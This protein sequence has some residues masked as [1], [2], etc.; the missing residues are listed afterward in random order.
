MINI[1]GVS[2]SSIAPIAAKLIADNLQSL[3]IVPS[4]SRAKVLA[5]DLEYFTRKTKHRIIN[6][7]GWDNF[8]F[9]YDAKNHDEL[10]KRISA[11]KSLEEG[12]P[13]IIICPVSSAIKKIQPRDCFS[14]SSLTIKKGME[15]NPIEL[16]ENLVKMG[17]EHTEII[18]G[19]GQFSNRGGILDIFTPDLDN[20]VRIEFFGDEVDDIRIFDIDTQRSVDNL[21]EI[22]VYPAIE[23]VGNSV[24]ERGRLK[25]IAEYDKAVKKAE[26]SGLNELKEK[27]EERKIYLLSLI[28]NIENT[29]LLENY[30]HY[31]YDETEYIWDYIKSGIILVD[32]PD[33]I[34]ETLE[35]NEEES[36][37]D[38][39]IL[40]ERGQAVGKD[41][42]SVSGAEDFKRVL[43]KDNVTVFT[44]FP[45][46]V[47]GIDDF[48]KVYNIE[49]RQPIHFEGRLN[50]LENQ[51]KVYI[52]KGYD[53]TLLAGNEEKIDNLREFLYRIGLEDK[54]TLDFGTLSKGIEYPQGKKV[55]LSEGDIFKQGKKKRKSKY[56]D[57][58]NKLKSFQ[59]LKTGDFVVH[60]NHGVGKFLGIEK[61]AFEGK[62]KDYIK[63]KYAGNDM[64]YVPVDSME[65]VQKYI[66]QEGV[67]PKINRL[68]G[69]E[70]K[71]T[72]AKAKSDIIILAKD[73]IKLYA[74][75]KMSK[76]Y[77]FKEDSIW[78]KEFEDSFY[79]E[80]TDDQLRAIED[81]KRDMESP[82]AMDRLILGDVG[83]GKTEVA[84]RGIFKCISE[85]KQAAFLVPTTILANQHYYTIKERMEKFPFI[86]EVLSR[87]RT[88]KQQK[89]I[90]EKLKEKKVDVIVGTH[91]LLSEDVKFEDLG[92]LVIDEEQRFGVKDK[93]KIKKLKHNVDVLTLSATPI[94]RTL[95][96]SLTGIKDMSIIEEP[97]EDRYPVQT[98]VLEQ[99]DNV[100]KEVI[101]REI[102][103]GGQVYIVFNRVRG[104]LSVKEKI[105]KLVPDISVAVGHG[106]MN[107][108]NLENIMM[109][110]IEGEYDCLI[111]TTI[112]ESGLDIPNANTMIIMDADR[113]GL[114]QLYQLKGRVGRG[115]KMAYCYLM[116]QK[117]KTLNEQ[118]EKRLKAIR[119]FTEFGAG[120]K[121]AMRDL[122]IRGAGSMLGTAQS[123]HIMNIGY[124]L[125]C[126]MVDDAV[127]T[128]QGEVVEERN[129]EILIELPISCYIPDTYIENESIKLE[130]Y[131]KIATVADYADEDEVIDELLDRFGD[132]PQET[133]NLIKIAHIRHLASDIGITKIHR[134]KDSLTGPY[135]NTKI[136][137]KK[138]GSDTSLKN[139]MTIMLD[140]SEKNR[141]SPF[142]LMNLTEEMKNKVFV[143]GGKKP[144]IKFTTD[145]KNMISDSIKILTILW[146]DRKTDEKPSDTYLM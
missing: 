23:L 108:H 115:N 130:M 28:D 146:N 42:E 73:L 9:N 110:F 138:T 99:D 34:Y 36:K 124:D 109:D 102:Q 19:K 14:K 92:L 37:R 47:K 123:G 89:E 97:P 141:L 143:H 112:I 27:I 39:Q 93:E 6:I 133:V 45:K 68:S 116:Y 84:I 70:W 15:E 8:L 26:N 131:K 67:V 72:K 132:V 41:Y 145:V 86:I 11:L 126:K 61:I 76:G 106:Q 66:G 29:Q 120:F 144:F 44:P 64:L 98:Y 50:V 32:D 88:P 85:G 111:A 46:K 48:D 63:I 5:G 136:R 1:T 125:Y 12:E 55:W 104:I 31:F 20:P 127:R 58:G 129:E 78:Q 53:I 139:T 65:L 91:R 52:N 60:E 24:L 95:N 38:F 51:L 18:E 121:V 77:S 25:L 49:S 118:A 82:F 100:L 134:I 140:F 71:E 107:E 79:Y 35:F 59:D 30:I 117:N 21:K 101:L 114:S 142:A 94:P 16:K 2:D 119:E 13:V 54:I 113:Y 75:R 74:Q 3:I 135:I 137:L 7:P 10:N 62:Y 33:R 43:K 105:E 122:E 128:L 80:E 40:L 103:R 90:I 17:Y 57:K 81:M 96:M 69:G 56:K 22:S 87:F 4:E 83:Y